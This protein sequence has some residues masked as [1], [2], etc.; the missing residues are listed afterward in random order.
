MLLQQARGSGACGSRWHA[1]AH[2]SNRPDRREARR[3]KWLLCLNALSSEERG[4]RVPESVPHNP[5]NEEE[6]LFRFWHDEKRF[7]GDGITSLA[8][9][10]LLKLGGLRKG[11]NVKNDPSNGQ[12]GWE[13]Y[14]SDAF[15]LIMPTTFEIPS[16]MR[17]W[18]AY[19]KQHK[20]GGS[21]EAPDP[22]ACGPKTLWVL[23]TAENLGL[24]ASASL[25]NNYQGGLSPLES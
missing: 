23:K 4:A 3:R 14:G 8:Q 18:I 20:E 24:C 13:A 16:Q 5:S 12:M 6:P 22:L 21:G 11:G 7:K 19:L 10:T 1:A 17:Q 2:P 25:Q 15:S 9:R